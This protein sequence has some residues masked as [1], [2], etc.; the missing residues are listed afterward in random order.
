[1]TTMQRRRR[2]QWKRNRK[3]NV[4]AYRLQLW[5]A[6]PFRPHTL[7]RHRASAVV[8]CCGCAD[9]GY[10]NK[11]T[12]TTTTVSK[13]RVVTYGQRRT[14]S[15]LGSLYSNFVNALCP[16]LLCPAVNNKCTVSQHD[17][18][19]Q[20]Y[21]HE[22]P[23]QEG[24]RH[25]WRDIST[26]SGENEL[27]RE[28][29]AWR[30]SLAGF[31][32]DR[33]EQQSWSGRLAPAP[34]SR[35]PLSVLQVLLMICNYVDAKTLIRSLMFVNKK[36]YTVVADNYLW[37]KRAQLKYSGSD[38]AFMLTDNYNGET[39]SSQRRKHQLLVSS[40]FF[41][42][43]QKTPLTGSNLSGTPS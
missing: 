23:A 35:C 9:D 21:P 38:V 8:E 37:K 7:Y 20:S 28:G 10:G 19:P 24:N 33:G 5:F 42:V 30:Y 16:L 11:T 26:F 22:Y 2:R 1:M 6:R 34:C 15:T 43:P 4:T 32:S 27:F 14:A 17:V 3:P 29:R 31:D 40:L 18:V 13:V 25:C 12:K 41:S 36:F 39:N